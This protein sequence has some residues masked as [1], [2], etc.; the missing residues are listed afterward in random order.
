MI[1]YSASFGTAIHWWK[2][3]P[4][5]QE[6]VRSGSEVGLKWVSITRFNPFLDRAPFDSLQLISTRFGA[7]PRSPQRPTTIESVR[8]AG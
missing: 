4:P 7:T 8:S 3:L 5:S 6:G 1:W 2:T